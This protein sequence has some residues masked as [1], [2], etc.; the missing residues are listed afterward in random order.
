MRKRLHFWKPLQLPLLGKARVIEIYHA[1]KLFY[2][3][4][5]YPIPPD[6]EKEVADAFKDY[7]TFPKKGNIPQVSRKEMEKLR[8]DGGLKLIN[9]AL[10]S[11]TPKVHWLIRIVTDENLKVNLDLFNSL[12]GV[13]S[14]NLTGQ[15]IIFA[16]NSYVKRNLKTENSFYK[17]A[18]D[19]ITK[20]YREKHYSDENNENVFFNPIFTRTVEDEVHEE[21]IRPFKGNRLLAGIR[22]YGDLL[23]AEDT[24]QC[25]RLKA[26]VR[27]KIRS[28]DNIRASASQNVIYA[29]K[30]R[31]EYTFAPT[32]KMVTQNIIYRE[33]IQFQSTEHAYQIK[34][35]DEE[36]GRL[37]NQMIDWDKVWESVH[38]QF[39]TEK[40]K[41]TVWEQIHLNFYT[42]Y[43]YNKWHNSLNPCPLCHKIP[44][45]IFHIILDCRFTK[46]MW[47]RIQ[48][49]LLK[50]LRI[51]I[52]DSEKAFGLQPRTKKETQATILRNWITFS[53]RHL[54]MQEERKA[55]YIQN[56]H[57]RSV[58]SFFSKFNYAT[59]EEIQ[60]KKLQY[61]FR[62]LSKKFEKIVTTN[63]AVASI[64][65]GEY[66]WMKIM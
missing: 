38:K 50:I 3:S 52:T 59:K 44:E 56:Y 45:D 36:E 25:P 19:G 17:E 8:L 24:I 13:Q 35:V 43:N 26:A 16:E 31:K 1:S 46:I 20:L 21:T 9:I 41:S 57:K 30:S 27:N 22:S 28:I 48:K 12:I 58:E 42:T 11:Q 4:N 63:N 49:V 39:H 15:D 47:K 51:P 18:L 6:K 53:L 64:N 60:T 29:L 40:V 61:D 2:A 37:P 65:A 62:G 5:F 14:G 10:K 33:L 34:W 55:Y 32:Y 7:I 54:I 66:T 23:A